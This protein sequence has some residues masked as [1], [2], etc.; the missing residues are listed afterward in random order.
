MQVT[1]IAL[2]SALGDVV[3]VPALL[4]AAAMIYLIAALTALALARPR[5]T[6]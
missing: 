5:Y 4:R 3:G 2:A 6:S 1:G